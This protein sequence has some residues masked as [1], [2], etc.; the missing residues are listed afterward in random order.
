MLLEILGLAT[1][2]AG[3][4]GFKKLNDHAG[5]SLARKK[6]I[7][8]PECG[9]SEVRQTSGSSFKVNFGGSWKTMIDY[10]CQNCGHKFT[11]YE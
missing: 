10:K 11:R 7:H 6:G 4:Y 8:C 1:I 5:D 9:S 3:G 2:A